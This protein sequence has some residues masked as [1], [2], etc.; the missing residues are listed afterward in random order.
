MFDFITKKPDILPPLTL[1]DWLTRGIK[2]VKDPQELTELLLSKW[3]FASK[4][5]LLLALPKKAIRN[6]TGMRLLES[7]LEE[8]GYTQLAQ[9]VRWLSFWNLPKKN[10]RL[11]LEWSYAIVCCDMGMR[12]V[13]QLEIYIQEERKAL[14][15][16][17]LGS[18]TG[19]SATKI[20]AK[21][22]EY[23]KA[24]QFINED[25]WN[26]SREIWKVE[27]L[28]PAGALSR[29]FKSCRTNPD[30]Y[31]CQWLRQDCA[32]RGGCC[33]RG[34]GCCEKART[35][36]RQWN[37]G[38]CT[39][40]CG[41]CIRTQGR[42]DINAAQCELEELNSFRIAYYMTQYSARVNRAYIWGLSFMDELD[43][44]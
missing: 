33:G 15:K 17:S 38:H 25:Y 32:R 30:W 8:S 31:L 5:K 21:L 28:L 7:R 3:P 22:D 23:D 2:R 10:L 44:L 39:G 37:R 13:V 18:S 12:R 41:C 14:E 29:A 43:L 9:V 34:C 42:K 19:K 27:G 1:E 11:S 24:L 36:N 16:E 35:A 4:T 6:D 20:T 40:M 26:L